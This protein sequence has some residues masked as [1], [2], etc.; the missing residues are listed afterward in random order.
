MSSKRTLDFHPGDHVQ[1]NG[2]AAAIVVVYDKD[3]SVLLRLLAPSARGAGYTRAPFDELTLVKPA[4]R[5]G[6]DEAI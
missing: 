3:R 2:A 4:K 5:D 6:D 1:F